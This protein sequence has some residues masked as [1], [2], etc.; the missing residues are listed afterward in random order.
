MKK[1]ILIQVIPYSWNLSTPSQKQKTK[2][3]K[4]MHTWCRKHINSGFL[5]CRNCKYFIC[6]YKWTNRYTTLW[7]QTNLV[8]AVQFDS[9]DNA[10]FH[11]PGEEKQLFFKFIAELK[12]QMPHINDT[13]IGKQDPEENIWETVVPGLRMRKEVPPQDAGVHKVVFG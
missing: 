12:L 13:A 7:R 1:K 8:I 3:E 5:L 6:T 10:R 4:E 9:T 2:N 11:I